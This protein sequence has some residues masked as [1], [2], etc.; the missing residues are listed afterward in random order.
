ME[1]DTQVRPLPIRRGDQFVKRAHEYHQISRARRMWISTSQAPARLPS[2]PGTARGGYPRHGQRRRPAEESG[3]SR[4]GARSRHRRLLRLCVGGGTDEHTL[5]G[6]AMA[7]E[8]S[9]EGDETG[10]GP[11]IHTWA[12]FIDSRSP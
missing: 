7:A 1:L 4:S 8:C 5:E 3:K 12:G 10:T 2:R 9:G 11:P 6:A